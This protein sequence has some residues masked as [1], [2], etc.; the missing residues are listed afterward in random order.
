MQL[1]L[2]VRSN[3][4]SAARFHRA[5]SWCLVAGLCI[6]L[7]ALTQ[8][9]H[10]ITV[11]PDNCEACYLLALSSDGGTPPVYPVVVALPF[12]QAFWIAAHRDYGIPPSFR[13]FIRPLP[14]APPRV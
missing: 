5:T 13:D 8:H 2:R 3:R 14:Q 4:A 10:E 9:H 6:Q 7:M 1:T 11:H 12:F